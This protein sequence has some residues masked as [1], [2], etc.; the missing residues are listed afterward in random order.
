MYSERLASARVRVF[1]IH[2]NSPSGLRDVSPD[3]LAHFAARDFYDETRVV[4]KQ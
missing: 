2:L 4:G 3:T 1:K